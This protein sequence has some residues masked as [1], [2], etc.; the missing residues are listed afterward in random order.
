MAAGI[1]IGTGIKVKIKGRV[2][3]AVQGAS[4]HEV[5]AAD[6]HGRENRVVLKL[7]L[8]TIG[9]AGIVGL[10]N[11]IVVQI[12]AEP[13]IRVNSVAADAVS[14]CAIAVCQHRCRHCGR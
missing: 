2:R 14:I 10:D 5:A 9:V 11:R 8:V 12:D 4:D 3:Q 13:R 6:G 1:P 7:V